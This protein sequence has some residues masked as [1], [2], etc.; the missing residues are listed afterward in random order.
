MEKKNYRR[1]GGEAKPRSKGNPTA[2]KGKG[3]SPKGDP[4]DGGRPARSPKGHPAN[5]KGKGAFPKGDSRGAEW[6][7]RHK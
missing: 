7:P 4:T 5:T 6:S 2:A 3:Q 1:D